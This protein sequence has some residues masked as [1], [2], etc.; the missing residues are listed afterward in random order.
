MTIFNRFESREEDGVIDWQEFLAYYQTSK[1]TLRAVRRAASGIHM[2]PSTIHLSSLWVG[3]FHRQTK[4]RVSIYHALANLQDSWDAIQATLEQQ[5]LTQGL[6]ALP[7]DEGHSLNCLVFSTLSTQA[8][9]QNLKA[10]RALC[11]GLQINQEILRRISVIFKCVT[12]RSAVSAWICVGLSSSW[13][14]NA[15][16]VC[17]RTACIACSAKTSTR[18]WTLCAVASEDNSS[19]AI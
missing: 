15:A 9:P 12:P 18:S 19:I 5:R 1:T 4:P 7:E 14:L 11:P 17:V 8:V 2:Q 13:F 6:P 10:L 3:L 16:S